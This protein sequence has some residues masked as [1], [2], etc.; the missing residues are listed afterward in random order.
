VTTA[1][2]SAPQL[3]TTTPSTGKIDPVTAV[4]RALGLVG[5]GVDFAGNPVLTGLTSWCLRF[6]GSLYGHSIT[7]INTAKDAMNQWMTHPSNNPQD[8]PYGSVVFFKPGNGVD[9]AGHIGLA[10]GNGEMISAR[11]GKVIKEKITGIW[12]QQFAGWGFVPWTTIPVQPINPP[13]TVKPEQPLPQTTTPPPTVNPPNEVQQQAGFTFLPETLPILTLPGG[14][15]VEV[16]FKTSAVWLLKL[17]LTLFAF[18]LIF[19]GFLKLF[20]GDKIIKETVEKTET[21][22]KVAAKI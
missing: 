7:G 4:G 6:I 13:I 18:G 8:A 20:N 12:Q 19:Y 3:Q 5:G 16:P 9:D 2:T 15:K 21:A 10:T 1:V 22:A 14:G 17:F 11:S